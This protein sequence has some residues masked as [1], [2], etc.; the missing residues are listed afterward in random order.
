MLKTYTIAVLAGTTGARLDERG[1]YLTIVSNTVAS[2]LV[3]FDDEQP[4]QFF[5]H[6][7]YPGPEAGF[8]HIRFVAD[9]APCTLVVHVSEKPIGYNDIVALGGMAT[10]LS[11]I[12]ADTTL[13]NAS[14]IAGNVILATLNALLTTIDIDTGNIDSSLDAVEQE[15]AGGPATLQLADFLLPISPGPGLAVLAANA[16]ATEREISAPPSNGAGLVY[17]GI[18]AA[19]STAIDKFVVLAAGDLWWSD[20]EKGAIYGCSSTGAEIVNAREC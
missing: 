4:Q 13:I 12:D 1:H 17:L 9:V 18:T 11:N 3:G 6:V 10:S 7:C 2:V 20:R 16:A 19:R 15:I 8:D 5:P 14:V